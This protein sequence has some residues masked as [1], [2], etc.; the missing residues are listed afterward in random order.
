LIYSDLAKSFVPIGIA[1]MGQKYQ[2]LTKKFILKNWIFIDAF[3]RNS[4]VSNVF[5]EIL[6][7][8]YLKQ[9]W[10]AHGPERNFFNLGLKLVDLSIF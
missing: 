3:D 9:T 8:Y 5:I 4:L 7:K 6:V 10:L 1:T 2:F